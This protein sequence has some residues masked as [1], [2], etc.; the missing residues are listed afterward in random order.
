MRDTGQGDDASGPVAR[1][2]ASV[3]GLLASV[4]D[5]GRTRLELLATE[6]QEEIRRTAVLLALGFVALFAAGMASLMAGLT[7]IFAFW[8]SHRVLVSVL[9]TLAYGLGAMAAAM[10]LSKRLE[11]H[12]GVLADTMAELRRDRDTLRG[13]S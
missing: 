13:E 6:V 1:L 9:V 5:I 7:L 11:R 4:V 3:G 8:D 2:L 10:S 12:P